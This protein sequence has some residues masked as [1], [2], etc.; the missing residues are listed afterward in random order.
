MFIT[1][2]NLQKIASI[3]NLLQAWKEFIRGK[4]GKPDVQE[5]SLCLMDNLFALHDDLVRGTYRHGSYRAFRIADPKPRQ[6]HKAMVRD[7]LLHHAAH[8]V[9]YPLFDRMFIADSYSCRVGKGMH[10]AIRRFAEFGRKVSKN[11]TKTCW[12]L[13]CDIKK[14]FASIDHEILLGILSRHVAD[15]GLLGLLR[16]IISSFSSGVPGVG[17]PLGNLTSQLFANVYMN[18]LDQ[19]MKY[20]MRLRHYVR[21]ADDFVV[22]SIDR[23]GLERVLAQTAQFLGERL[24]LELHPQ[25]IF[26]KT[27]ASGVDFL[28][29][30]HFA[31]HRVLRTAT[32]RRMM[33]RITQSPTE[34]M[35]ASYLGMLR[36][37][38]ARMLK[39]VLSEARK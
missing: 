22:L 39:A 1:D 15:H 26:I 23:A 29:W 31:D 28:G 2:L 17:L 35:R 36:H 34:A 13:Q 32:K 27:L 4:R 30:V 3:E 19:W 37:G 11:N 33:K 20:G 9:L 18:K 14:F 5:F 38:N 25:K 10:R 6:I 21:Y 16:E 7:R 12:V 8:R 24:K